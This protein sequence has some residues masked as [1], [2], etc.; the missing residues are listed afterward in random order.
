MK[1]ARKLIETFTGPPEEEVNA[2][3]EIIKRSNTWQEANQSLEPYWV[4][5]ADDNPILNHTG[6]VGGFDHESG[7]VELN[8]RYFNRHGV[9]W[10]T[11]IE[12]ELTHHGQMRR[13]WNRGGDLKQIKASH[14]RHFFDKNGNIRM[15]RYTTHPLEMQALARNAVSSAKLSG[16][17]AQDLLRRGKLGALAPLPPGNRKRFGKYAY[18]MLTA[19]GLSAFTKLRTVLLRE[20]SLLLVAAMLNESIVRVCASCEQ[21]I[22]PQ[23][24][25][26]GED[27]SH[28]YCKRHILQMA[29]EQGLPDL[30]TAYASRPDDTFPPDL[31]KHPEL[32]DTEGTEEFRRQQADFRQYQSQH[33]ARR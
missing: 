14:E 26:P 24:V 8:A 1:S 16:R 25:R 10:R 19:E 6:A 11:V 33:L 23:R 5:F 27:K 22:G 3:V 32:V 21:E 17:N 2:A 30:A 7:F 4:R 29:Q 20:Q 13:A 28:S 18:Q 31:A 9:D 12:H 15:D